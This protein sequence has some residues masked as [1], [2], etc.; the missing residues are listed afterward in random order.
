[1]VKAFPAT[2]DSRA[3]PVYTVPLYKMRLR[4]RQSLDVCEEVAAEPDDHDDIYT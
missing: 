3:G 4:Q 1:M 2:G